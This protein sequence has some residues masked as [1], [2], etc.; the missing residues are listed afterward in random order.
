MRV[1]QRR[2]SVHQQVVTKIIRR[3]VGLDAIGDQCE[4]HRHDSRIGDDEVEW[5]ALGR[6]C[7]RA[8]VDTFQ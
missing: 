2:H 7:G 5:V 3:E 6:A 4:R 8:S 1:Q